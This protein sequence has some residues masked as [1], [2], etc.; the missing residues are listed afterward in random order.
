MCV[1]F[2]QGVTKIELHPITNGENR[3][4]ETIVPGHHIMKE[5]N[6][7]MAYV[8]QRLSYYRP[9]IP[10]NFSL[11]LMGVNSRKINV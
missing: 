9:L 10:F 6:G 11:I 5:R 3:K 4:G 8:V 2:R 7:R 1:F